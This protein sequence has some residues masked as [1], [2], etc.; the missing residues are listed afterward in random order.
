MSLGLVPG[1]SPGLVPPVGVF[2][3]KALGV[4]HVIRI[5]AR[6]ATLGCPGIFTIGW[7]GSAAGFLLAV[8][9]RFSLGLSLVFELGLLLVFVLGFSLKPLLEDALGLSLGLLLEFVLQLLL[10]FVLEPGAAALGGTEVFVSGCSWIVSGLMC[11]EC[12][13][14]S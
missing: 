1:V 3:S 4:W 6:S 5:V 10:G 13:L 11:W 12:H 14:G 9:L 7:T 2:L 8:L